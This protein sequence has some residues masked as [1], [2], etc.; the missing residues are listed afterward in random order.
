MEVVL[1][2]GRTIKQGM[3][4]EGGK[5]EQENINAT[6]ICEI[7]PE[8]MQQLGC[9]KSGDPVRV[10]TK[11]GE[12][13]IKAVETEQNP[14]GTIFIPM[15]IYANMVTSSETDS[16]GMPSYKG[17]SAIIESAPSQKIL[18]IKTLIQKEIKR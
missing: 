6:G 5:L 11:Y 10:K 14:R 16:T 7:N 17:I 15:G 18:D 1:I 9:I 8:D 12:I 4:L 2:S 3:A 13:V